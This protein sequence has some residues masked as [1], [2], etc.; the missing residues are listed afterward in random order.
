MTDPHAGGSALGLI[1]QVARILNSGLGPDETLRVV[2]A[3][4][5]AGLPAKSVVIWRREANA[6]TFA[7]V[8]VPTGEHAAFSLDD[9]PAAEAGTRRFPLVHGGAR[10][11]VLEIG[12]G[13]PDPAPDPAPIPVLCDL[14]APF[15]DSMTLSEDLALEVA[16]RS[17]EIEEQ[18]RF[19]S[20]VI[21]SLPVG[22]YVVD[23][24]YRI[25]V[26]N[27]KRET[28]TQ[29]LRRGEVVGRPVFEV[30]TGQTPAQLKAEFDR[31]FRDGEVHQLDIE[32][33]D[34]EEPHV[35]RISRIPMRLEG[36]AVTHVITIGEDVTEGRQVQR[37]VLQSEKLAAVGQL[38][39]GV[40]HEINNPL[41]T[42]AACVAAIEARLGSAADATV[43]EYLE[44]IDR[45]VLRCTHIV[46]GLLDF[47]RP[48]VPAPKGPVPLNALV[49][50]TLF[51]LKHHQRFKRLRVVRELEP[52]LPPVLVNDEQMIQ[53]FMAL[54]LNAVDA[55]EEAGTLTVRTRWS[56]ERSD[57]LLIEFADTGHGI[58]SADLPKI[59]EPFFT[60]KP[61]GRGTGLGLSVCYGILEQHLGHI[62]VDSESGRGSTFRVYLPIAVGV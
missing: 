43:G 30:L 24:D 61:P 50:Q 59:F 32:V 62:E 3:T 15:L 42:I 46:D 23:R 19:T 39:A 22:L 2:A 55:V 27:R 25:Q 36:D 52:E 53:V 34:R 40:M 47:S 6:S 8:T 29:G 57:E 26:W 13:R 48:K 31:V 12:F 9:L 41:A 20:L 37:R 60:T 38:A 45:E 35:F 21:D 1:G 18:R 58:P 17:R 28:G 11:G 33:P 49:E 7:G 51:L 16:S 44:I 5:R 10:L 14:L 4:V 56:P 54:M